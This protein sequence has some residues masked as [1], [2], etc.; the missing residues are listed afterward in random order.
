MFLAQVISEV[1]KLPGVESVAFTG[2]I[3]L[4]QQAWSNGDLLISGAK[5]ADANNP[6][7]AQFRPI[8]GDYASA[9]GLK[10]TSGRLPQWRADAELSEAIVNQEY[11]DRFMPGI[12][13]VGRVVADYN[14]KIVG[15]L[16]SVKQIG[17][18]RPAEPDVYAPFAVLY[19]FTQG[20]L[21]VRNRKALNPA[22]AAA[23]LAQ[24]RAIVQRID[25]S[26]P[27]FD[28]QT[29][30]ALLLSASREI[31]LLTRTVMS[32][33]ALALLTTTLGLFCLCAF[34]VSR[35]RREFGLRLALGAKPLALMTQVL[36]SN[37]KFTELTWTTN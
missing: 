35:R 31:T 32:F 23:L 19:F 21:I 28:A 4:G 2:D 13:P 26:V 24:V 12:D 27:V 36:R 6:P 30:S 10:I 9:L 16:Q 5:G 14:L 20:Q 15:V 29:G 8:S 34:S 33:A 11:I 25:A 1:S 18:A 3:R 37:L 17:P 7:Y 22:A